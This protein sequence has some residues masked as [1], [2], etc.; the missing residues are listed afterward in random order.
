MD[1]KK[2]LES[3]WQMTLKHIVSLLLMT[4][5]MFII[6]FLT[7]GILA[8]VMMAGY[9]QSIV[10]MMR[11]GREPVIQDL[12]SQMR[13]FLP[14]LGFTI[15]AT[16]A[17][18]VGFGL[19]FLPGLIISVGLTFACIYMLPLMTDQQMGLMDA[20]RKS[21]Q[22]ATQGNVTD[23]IVVVVLFL[24]LIAIGCSVAIGSLFTQPF[25][26]VFLISTYLERM[27]GG[28]Q[29]P[30]PPPVPPVS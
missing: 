11:N 15:V 3:A 2:H 21:W 7:L 17:V 28:S 13:L 12:F 6:S 9:V 25:A 27:P 30:A 4:L 8:P 16:I 29:A 14:L 10:L 1:F 26:T 23:H 20:L 18:M 5:V 24:G 19:L 22:M